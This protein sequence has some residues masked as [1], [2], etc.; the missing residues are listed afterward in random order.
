M[1]TLFFIEL[2]REICKFIW[3]N[4]KPRI[5]KTILNNKRPGEITIPDL[6]LYYRA[7]VIKQNKTKQNKQTNKQKNSKKNPCM[8]LVQRQAGNQWN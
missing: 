8:I 6:K 1:S 4:K 2:E 3:N 7:I 5:A